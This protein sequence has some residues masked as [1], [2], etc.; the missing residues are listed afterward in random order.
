[1]FQ[2]AL[3]QRERVGCVG[4]VVDAKKEAVA[5][6]EKLGFTVLQITNQKRYH[7]LIGMF[8]PIGTIV[9]AR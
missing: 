4:V 2:L 1:M 6:Y 8:L 7:D 9:Q 3:E 5:F